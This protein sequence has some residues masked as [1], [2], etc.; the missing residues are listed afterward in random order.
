VLTNH[1]I[2]PGL[3]DSGSGQ[4]RELARKRHISG[5]QQRARL[6][7]QTDKQTVN[8]TSIL[9][10]QRHAYV[11]A[12]AKLRNRRGACG[13]DIGHI[14]RWANDDLPRHRHAISQSRA[15]LDNTAAQTRQELVFRWHAMMGGDNPR[16]ACRFSISAQRDPAAITQQARAE[17]GHA[18]GSF[19][20]RQLCE[21]VAEL[22]QRMRRASL[23]LG[24]VKHVH[25]FKGYTKL[26]QSLGPQLALII[27]RRGCAAHQRYDATHLPTS[28]RRQHPGNF[29]AAQEYGAARFW[30]Y[31]RVIRQFGQRRVKR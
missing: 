29:F 1:L 20:D 11:C 8:W 23:V 5:R 4:T 22:A 28:N 27:V 25:S 31:D 18:R 3:F 15:W 19:L 30:R 2:Q 14:G 24:G 12:Y 10:P 9:R 17:L 13:R 26:G 21:G 16:R 6:G 7:G